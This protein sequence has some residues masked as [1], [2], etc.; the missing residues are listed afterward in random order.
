MTQA[1]GANILYPLNEE[2][3]L[4]ARDRA[5]QIV[6]RKVAGDKPKPEQ[7]QKETISEY[8]QRFSNMLTAMLLIAFAGAF[9]VSSF[10]VFSAGRDHY[11]HSM[12]N[13]E[14]WQAVIVGVAIVLLAEFLT[15]TSVLA[16]RILLSG[17][18]LWQVIMAIP[19]LLG[20]VI[21]IMANMVIGKPVTA[22]DWLV[23]V[24]P[25]VSVIFLSLILELLVLAEVRR[26]HESQRAYIEALHEWQYKSAE[27]EKLT[28]WRATY[29]NELKAAIRAKNSRGHGR[30][31]RE[32]V[33][34]ALDR[35][36]W[37]ALVYREL[38]ADQWLL[39]REQVAELN[40]TQPGQ[41]L[42]GLLPAPHRNGAGRVNGNSVQIVENVSGRA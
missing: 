37:S 13:G 38:D 36:G 16:A 14:G 4:A 23:T 34:Q 1:A 31:E 9:A 2:E 28:A 24:A 32:S 5:A 22:W 25:P 18:L 21:A 12:T 10:N 6:V 19:A 33:M 42:P 27:P 39:D 26:R 20:V 30:S 29:A 7:F 11:L 3:R 17:R 40:P 35:A 15:I 41:H 8:P